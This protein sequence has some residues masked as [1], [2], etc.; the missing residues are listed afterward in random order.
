MI[1]SQGLLPF[2]DVLTGL[3]G[4]IILVNVILAVDL[5]EK[6]K[7]PVRVL[8]KEEEAPA[9][10]TQRRPVYMI[11]SSAG[12]LIGEELLPIPESHEQFKALSRAI[13]HAVESA[14]EGGYVLALIRPDGYKSFER[15]R[16]VVDNLGFRLGYEPVSSDWELVPQ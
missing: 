5:A 3:V 9:K 7:I 14:G 16:D 11:C 6:D 1:K 13:K 8:L 15:L 2:M 10:G 4:I 12:I